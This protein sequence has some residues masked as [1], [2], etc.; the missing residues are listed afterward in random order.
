MRKSV[1]KGKSEEKEEDEFMEFRNNEKSS[2]KNF[3]ILIRIYQQNFFSFICS[4]YSNI[5]TFIIKLHN[6]SK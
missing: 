4:P 5:F 6:Y 1:E 3:M 2:H